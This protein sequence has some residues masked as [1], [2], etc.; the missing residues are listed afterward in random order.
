MKRD[1]PV[2]EH[3]LIVGDP[4]KKE[5]C[6]KTSFEATRP[7]NLFDP[8]GVR[9]WTREEDTMVRSEDEY[10]RKIFEEE[11]Q[12]DPYPYS[13]FNRPVVELGR[14]GFE[15]KFQLL[16]NLKAGSTTLIKTFY[17]GFCSCIFQCIHPTFCSISDQGR[18]G[19]RTDLR[20]S[21][22]LHRL[23]ETP[24]RQAHVRNRHHPLQVANNLPL[25]LLYLCILIVELSSSACLS[26]ANE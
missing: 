20:P 26:L 4:R 17:P 8:A 12:V 10:I 3:S 19:E 16:R 5:E 7:A 13:R 21:Q 23:R 22:H 24:H 15:I 2:P 11:V 6:K 14:N 18:G 1:L 25:S 9:L